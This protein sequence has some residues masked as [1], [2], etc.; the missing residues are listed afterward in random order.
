MVLS[1]GLKSAARMRLFQFGYR[2][3]QLGCLAGSLKSKIK[4]AA[5]EVLARNWYLHYS[6]S[7]PTT[8]LQFHPPGQQQWLHE[9]WL[10]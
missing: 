2:S 6:M 5:L 1:L 4:K 10:P 9:A 7:C 8:H 3:L